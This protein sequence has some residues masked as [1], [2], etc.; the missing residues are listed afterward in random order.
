MPK[1]W[2]PSEEILSMHY[3]M[4]DEDV[5]FEC[6]EPLLLAMANTRFGRDLLCISQD[7]PKIV[8]MTKN[9]VHCLV[10]INGE[11]A[12]V[13][14]DFRVGAKWAN[15]IRF[16]WPQFLSYA[17]YFDFRFPIPVQNKEGVS[18]LTSAK[19]AMS[20]STLTVY[21]DPN[22]E[23]T[24][25]DGWVIASGTNHTNV[26]DSSS[27]N[28][29]QSDTD[30]TNYATNHAS[31]PTYYIFRSEFLFDTSTLTGSASISDAVLSLYAIYANDPNSNSLRIVTSNPASNTGVT[32]TDYGNFGSTAQANDITFATIGGATETYHDFT[33]DSTG[34]GNVSKT[35]I[36]KFGM[37]CTRDIGYQ[38]PPNNSNDGLGMYS[39]DTTGTSKDPKLVITYTIA[40]SLVALERT[41]I[42]GVMRGVCRP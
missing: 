42:R 29:G 31:L 21:P 11:T 2:L 36:S 34:K 24:T 4:L 40:S 26:V 10:E 37:R 19:M 12:T 41:P 6:C 23:T 16:R 33:F 30:G 35:G 1:I 15:V 22:P 9:S 7:Y 14:A 13:L 5:W 39:A 18:E 27:G 20:L 32:N 17:R 25:F 3:T 8:K 28:E 38:A